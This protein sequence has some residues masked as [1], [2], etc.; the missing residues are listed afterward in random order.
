M[1]VPPFIEQ[2]TSKATVSLVKELLRITREV[3]VLLG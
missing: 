2:H 1:L 3:R